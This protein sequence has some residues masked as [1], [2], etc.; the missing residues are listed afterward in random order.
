M[1]TWLIRRVTNQKMEA[2]PETSLNYS[3]A[4]YEWWVIV[5]GKQFGGRRY[6]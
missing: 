2:L 6:L 4:L 1:K 3:V 5:P